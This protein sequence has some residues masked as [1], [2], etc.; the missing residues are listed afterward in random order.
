MKVLL[1]TDT[2]GGVW[3]YAVE[4]SRALARH[5]VRIALA[6]MG[7]PL[8]ASQRADLASLRNVIPFESTYNLEWMQDPWDDVRRAGDWLLGIERAFKPDVVHLN[9]YAHGALPWHAPTI[10]AAHSCVLSWW[11]AVK[12]ED[13]PASWDRYREEV[14][15]GI[16][17]ADA[18]V[19]PSKDMLN[20]AIRHY[21]PFDNAQV[22]YNAR[23]PGPYVEPTPKEPFVLSAG[24]LWDDAKNLSALAAIASELPWPVYVAGDD[25]HPDGGQAATDS[26]HMLGK[27]APDA[28]AGWLRR[29]AIYALPARYEPFGLSILEAA[30]AGCALVLGDIP[31]LREI[32]ADAAIFVPP[33][34]PAALAQAITELTRDHAKRSAVGARARTRASA[35]FPDRMAREYVALYRERIDKRIRRTGHLSDQSS[36]VLQSRPQTEAPTPCAS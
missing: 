31:S 27:L 8:S 35:Y 36:R 26:V 21:G 30:L 7:G 18:V 33:E 23:T 28:L 22:I 19:A 15:R 4:L 14:T 29:A 34:N 32:W 17:A 5:D 1:T 9:G 10:V 25:Q 24:R 13:A 20:T 16:R 3:T 11:R 12:G 2:V 6:T